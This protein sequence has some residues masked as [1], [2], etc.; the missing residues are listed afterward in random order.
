MACSDISNPN[1]SGSFNFVIFICHTDSDRCRNMQDQY[2][3]QGT[4]RLSTYTKWL[5]CH[6]WRLWEHTFLHIFPGDRSKQTVHTR[7]R[8]MFS[9]RLI[10]MACIKVI[11]LLPT[12]VYSM[13]WVGL[14]PGTWYT[15]VK[16]ILH[17]LI[18]PYH[19]S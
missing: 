9:T 13:L 10:I 8:E 15:P 4:H 12:D 6:V 16:P 18:E 5:Q 7:Y 11:H 17:C 19:R 1:Y 3:C 2:V 14:Y